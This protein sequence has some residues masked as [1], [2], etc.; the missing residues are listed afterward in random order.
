MK[1]HFCRW[2]NIKIF[3]YIPTLRDFSQPLTT[4]PAK[5][6]SYNLAVWQIQTPAIGPGIADTSW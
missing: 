2:K 5:M 6:P 3:D 1:D 4:I